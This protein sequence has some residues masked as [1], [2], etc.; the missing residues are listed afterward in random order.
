[1]QLRLTR[2]FKV[3]RRVEVIAVKDLLDGYQRRVDQGFVLGDC[4]YSAELS[5]AAEK[6]PGVFPCYEPVAADVPVSEKPAKLSADDWAELY[7]LMR[8]DK[9]KAFEVYA[10]HYGKTDGQVYWSDTHQLAG[11]FVVHRTAVEAE[12]GTE[13]IT[14][15]YL[16]HDA[17]MPF[18]TAIRQDLADRKADITYGTIRFIEADEETFLPWARQKSVCVVCNL[19]VRHTEE[20]IAKAKADFRKILDRVIEFKGS[21]FLTYHRWATP[22]QVSACYPNIRDFFRLKRKYDPSERF[23]SEWYRQYAAV[24]R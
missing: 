14:E 2:R 3:R 11:D 8:I 24:F 22:E 12:K 18:F 4:Q 20:G 6:H 13:M 19:H 10:A 5:G 15:V 21:F 23:Q 16:K 17:L 9:Q 7:R 1:M